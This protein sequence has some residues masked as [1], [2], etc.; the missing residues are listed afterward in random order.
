MSTVPQP[1]TDRKET[2]LLLAA[3]L[4]H[5]NSPFTC[6]RCQG[7]FVRVF[8]MDIYD[9]TGE[10]GFWALRC[11]QCGELLDPLILQNRISNPQS[12]LKGRSRQQS[13]KALT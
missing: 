11:L 9:S 12:V 1:L 6:H 4:Q 13:P 2:G 5:L 10:N 8:C 7:L 3:R